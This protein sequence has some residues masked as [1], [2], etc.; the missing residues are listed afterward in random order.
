MNDKW[1]EKAAYIDLTGRVYRMIIA[2]IDRYLEDPKKQTFLPQM[3][4]KFVIMYQF[5][6]LLR[7]EAFLDDLLYRPH[8]PEHQPH[9][10]EMENDLR[11]LLDKVKAKLDSNDPRVQEY[12]KDMEKNF[13]PEIKFKQD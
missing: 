9:L 7:G 8:I 13:S 6:R 12:I 1:D 5:F 2:E 10:Y 3:Y 4:P 11:V